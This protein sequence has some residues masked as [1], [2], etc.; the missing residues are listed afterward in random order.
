MSIIL[1]IRV[2]VQKLA[3]IDRRAAELGQD[4]SHYVRGLIEQDL[5]SAPKPPRHVFASEDLVG[6]VS[7]GI[8]AND[9]ATLWKIIREHA[10]A[11][12][13]KNR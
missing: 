9:S 10:R 12:H 11:R 13:E 1:T 6:C 4:R 5:R 3:R 2:P 8:K 7:T